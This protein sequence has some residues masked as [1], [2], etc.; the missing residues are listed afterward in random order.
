MRLS[1]VCSGGRKPTHDVLQNH[2][3]NNRAEKNRHC[4]RNSGLEPMRAA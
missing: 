2:N 4:I 1:Y 3:M